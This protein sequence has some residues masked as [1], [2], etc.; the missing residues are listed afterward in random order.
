MK[1]YGFGVDVGGTTCKIGLFET[2]GELLE[3][4]EIPTNT[5]NNGESIPRDIVAAVHNKMIE[6]DLR[7]EDVVG[8]GIGVPGAVTENGVVNKCV[9]LGWGVVPIVEQM[10]ELSGLKVR[11]ANDANIAALGEAWMGAGKGCHSIVMVTLGTGI[12]GG[13]VLNGKLYT[14]LNH[15]GLEVGHLVIEHHGRPCTCGR[16]GCFETYCSATALIRE[17]R[18]AMDADRGSL[19]WQTVLH[20]QETALPVHSLLC[21]IC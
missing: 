14:G 5:E 3:K 11:A 1:K 4:W 12:G 7:K 21:R 2:D 6:K 18:K 17:A 9:N 15:A 16:K 13:A 19:L 20:R 8:I 10:E